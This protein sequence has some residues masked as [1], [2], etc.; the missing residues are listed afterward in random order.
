MGVLETTH[1]PGFVKERKPDVEN[2]YSRNYYLNNSWQLGNIKFSKDQ[3]IENI[4]FK[5]DLVKQILEIKQDEAIYLVS[6]KNVDSFHWIDVNTGSLIQFDPVSR[7]YNATEAIFGFFEVIDE[8]T[9]GIDEYK[10]LVHHSVWLYPATSS[11]SLS[12]SHRSNQIYWKEEFYISRNGELKKLNNSR[13]DNLPVFEEYQD[14]VKTHIRKKGL[15]FR[16]REDIK[17]IFEYYIN[18]VSE[19]AN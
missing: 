15:Y 18:L 13:K 11:V 12:G 4:F 7:Y 19:S 3:Q 8:Q 14:L 1:L 17:E 9:T 5:Y 10:L 16:N 2:P 6:A